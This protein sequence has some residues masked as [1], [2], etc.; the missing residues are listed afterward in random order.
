MSDEAMLLDEM[1]Q[2]VALCESAQLAGLIIEPTVQLLA[3]CIAKS[4]WECARHGREYAEGHL[5]FGK[6]DS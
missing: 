1:R 6:T 5:P 4:A 3:A 2:R